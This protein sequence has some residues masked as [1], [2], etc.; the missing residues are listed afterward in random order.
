MAK[1]HGPKLYPLTSNV[2]V[3]LDDLL[4]KLWRNCIAEPAEKESSHYVKMFWSR[5]GEVVSAIGL[6]VLSASSDPSKDLILAGFDS[7]WIGCKQIKLGMWIYAGWKSR[8][9]EAH[10]KYLPDQSFAFFIKALLYIGYCQMITW[11]QGSC[12][13]KAY[14]KSAEIQRFVLQL[15]TA[16]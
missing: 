8:L 4:R 7:Q 14:E 16:P 10:K 5:F 2:P 9:D 11:K 15:P 1:P 6:E 13:K 12:L 3:L